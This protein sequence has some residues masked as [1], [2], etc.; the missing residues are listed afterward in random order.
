MSI[1]P[2]VLARSGPYG[3]GVR[4]IKPNIGL[5][6]AQAELQA[7]IRE[8]AK[9]TPRHFPHDFKIGLVP[10]NDIFVGSFAGTIY[11]I[12]GAVTL[13]LVIGCANARF[14]CL[15]VASLGRMN[16]RFAS[17]LVQAADG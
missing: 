5:S 9:E 3:H 2:Q 8:I 14:F 15:P 12:F 17:P 16:S 1:L 10:L 7:S 13:L 6:V 11:V 4:A